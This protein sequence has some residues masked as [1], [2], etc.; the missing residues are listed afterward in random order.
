MLWYYSFIDYQKLM[1]QQTGKLKKLCEE[2]KKL[3]ASE[4]IRQVVLVVG[5]KRQKI[6]RSQN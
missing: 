2:G 6:K 5:R 1:P 4:V 3:N